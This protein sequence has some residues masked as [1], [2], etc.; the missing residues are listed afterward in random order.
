VPRTVLLALLALLLTV[1]PAQACTDQALS[2]PFTPWLDYA[3]YEPAPDGGLE[4]GAAGWTL[5][6]ASVADGGQPWGGGSQSL[7]LPPGSSATTGPAC[8]T[9]AHPTLRFFARNTGAP[10]SGLVVSVIAGGVELPIGR[11]IAGSTWAPTAPLLLLA[12]LLGADSVRFRFVADGGAWSVDDV[13]VDPY[14]KG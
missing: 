4:S 2:R 3:Y 9:P 10:S 13:Y 12:N 11:V 14:R 7:S 6:G 1:P 8:V 5:S